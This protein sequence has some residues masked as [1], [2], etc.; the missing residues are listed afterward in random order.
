MIRS[1]I[2]IIIATLAGF[3]SAKFVEGAGLTL[4][5]DAAHAW[6]LLAGW[7][8]GAFIAALTALMIGQRWAPLGGLAAATVLLAAILA[9]SGGA[10]S[11]FMWPAAIGVIALGTYTAMRLT[12]AQMASPE[13]QPKTGLFDE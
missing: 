11:I 9:L 4:G 8:I 13:P 6:A 1:L 3:A 12:R 5:G 10:A 2:A 7:G